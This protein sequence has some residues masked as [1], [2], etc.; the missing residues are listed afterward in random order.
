MASTYSI[1]CWL[2]KIFSY[3]R[4]CARKLCVK[5]W[6]CHTKW[7]TD[8]NEVIKWLWKIK[9]YLKVKFPTGSCTHISNL[10]KFN[11]RISCRVLQTSLHKNKHT[12][13]HT[14]LH[15]HELILV[16][17]DFW[18]LLAR[19]APMLRN[20]HV[21]YTE[22][23]LSWFSIL[24]SHIYSFLRV[25]PTWLCI[26]LCNYTHINIIIPLFHSRKYLVTLRVLKYK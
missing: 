26:H 19:S 22:N 21:I 15:I 3:K 10:F 11:T 7:L 18:H 24:T 8:F 12:H 9:N 23:T 16:T 5:G 14:H 2:W 25:L 20:W 6:I 13:I 17:P 1:T 4:N